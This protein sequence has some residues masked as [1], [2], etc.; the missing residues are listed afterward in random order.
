MEHYFATCISDWWVSPCCSCTYYRRRSAGGVVHGSAC[1]DAG[2]DEGGG[3]TAVDHPPPAYL[4]PRTEGATAR[5]PRST[6]QA[7]AALNRNEAWILFSTSTLGSHSPYPHIRPPEMC[8]ECNAP[9]SHAGNECPARFACIFGAPLPGLA[10]LETGKKDAAAWTSDGV[11]M[12]HTAHAG[13]ASKVSEG[14]RDSRRACVS[15]LAGLHR[16]DRGPA[17]SGAAGPGPMSG[18]GRAAVAGGSQGDGG[19]SRL[20]GWEAGAVGSSAGRS[21]VQRVGVASRCERWR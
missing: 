5:Q 9:R 14:S 6:S 7:T 21:L 3:A 4:A 16:G 20:I 19:R 2:G 1:G 12:L 15:L 11:A 13:G 17:A 10:G 8:F 18:C